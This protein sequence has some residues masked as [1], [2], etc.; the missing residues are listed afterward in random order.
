MFARPQPEGDNPLDDASEA[1]QSADQAQAVLEHFTTS[2]NCE[3]VENPPRDSDLSVL[4]QRDPNSPSTKFNLEAQKDVVV[5]SIEP[6]SQDLSSS[7]IPPAPSQLPET[8]DSYEPNPHHTLS[9]ENDTMAEMPGPFNGVQGASRHNVALSPVGTPA[10]SLREKLRNMRANSAALSKIR[11]ES[12]RSARSTKSPSIIPDRLTQASQEKEKADEKP[13]ETSLRTRVTPAE[14]ESTF[15]NS[16]LALPSEMSQHLGSSSTLGLPQLGKMEF[17]I[18]LRMNERVSYQYQQTVYNYHHVIEK[19]VQEDVDEHSSVVGEMRTMIERVNNITTH[20]DL[21]SDMAMTQQQV[22]ATDEANWAETCSAKFQFLRHFIDHVRATDMHVVILASKGR[23][24][25]ILETFLKAHRAMYV[26]PDTMQ[27]SNPTAQ[28]PL[29]FTLLASTDTS[30]IISSAGLV[31]GFD[32][33]ANAQNPQV[34]AVRAHMLNIGQLSPMIHLLVFNSAEHINRCLPSSLA[35][36]QRLQALV[37]GVA[38][39]RKKVGQLPLEIMGPGAAAEEVAALLAAG[40]LE[41]RCV[42]PPMP[43][44]VDVDFGLSS[45]VAGSSTQEASQHSTVQDVAP[46][47]LLLKR[48]M[49]R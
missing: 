41:D 37:S 42:L 24:L 21:D 1:P 32:H 8:F 9:T 43:K 31:I 48:A 29:K 34:A 16:K 3:K 10:N 44:L 33:S 28:G 4:C 23:L 40:G 20:V 49:V 35:G 19:F 11:A 7:Q 17:A 18:P 30:S 6:G 5:E 38:Q 12:P 39:S 14:A 36:V 25:D 27:R 15:H 2:Q 22:S 26:R 47:S 46:S 45:S 13:L